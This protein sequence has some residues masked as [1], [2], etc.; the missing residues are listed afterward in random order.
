M[1]SADAVEPGMVDSNGSPCRIK[2]AVMSADARHSL[3]PDLTDRI[4]DAALL[5]MLFSGA[6]IAVVM[7]LLL[8][9][10]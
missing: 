6:A 7:L 8:I 2:E 9:L 1:V 3:D 10:F 4:Q 5:L